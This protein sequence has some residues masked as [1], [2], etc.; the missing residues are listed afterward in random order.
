MSHLFTVAFVSS[1]LGKR[2]KKYCYH[3]C[4]SVLPVFSTRRFMV[5]SL[6]FR[7]L[8]HFEFLFVYS[9]RKHSNLMYFT[10]SSPVF[11]VPFIEETSL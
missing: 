9:V 7:Y 8:I 11:P 1:G 5:S 3:L 6:I 10:Y 4:Q 2:S